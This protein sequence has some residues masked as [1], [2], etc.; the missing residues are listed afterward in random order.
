[1]CIIGIAFHVHPDYPL[2]VAAN[3]DEY[4]A[5]ASAAVR[6][7]QATPRVIGGLDLTRGGTWMGATASGL[8]VG[9]TNRRTVGPPEPTR[10]SRGEIV[11]AALQATTVD[12]VA[13][14]LEGIDALEYNPFNVVFGTARDLRVAYGR[15][16]QSRVEVLALPPGLHVL[17]NDSMGTP[18][19]KVTRMEMLLSPRVGDTPWPELSARIHRDVLCDHVLPPPEQVPPHPPWIDDATARSLQALCV[20]TPVYGTRSSTIVAVERDAAG[21]RGVHYAFSSGPPCATALEDV[22]SLLL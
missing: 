16:D 15:A 4:Y 2:L 13:R 21:G 14:Y 3:R 22:S 12:G 7:L 6:V 5:R 10:R 19:P 8:F 18:M 17:D 20:H 11:I 1:M 9:L